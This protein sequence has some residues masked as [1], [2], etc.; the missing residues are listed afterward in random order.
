[1]SGIFSLEPD[2]FAGQAPVFGDAGDELAA[3]IRRL[4]ASIDGEGRCWGDDEPGRAFEKTYRPDAE[5]TVQN[6]QNLTSIL[7]ATGA[8][9]HNSAN[10]FDH[11]DLGSAADCRAALTDR[12]SGSTVDLGAPTTPHAAPA[13]LGTAPYETPGHHRRRQPPSTAFT[14]GPAVSAPASEAHTPSV[15]PPA[16]TDVPDRGTHRPG[17]RDAAECDRGSYERSRQGHDDRLPGNPHPRIVSPDLPGTGRTTE[18]IRATTIGSDNAVG[19]PERSAPSARPGTDARNPGG[20]RPG[21]PWQRAKSR[22]KDQKKVPKR[23]NGI[24]ALDG[25]DRPPDTTAP[26]ELSAP[27]AGKTRGTPWSERNRGDSRPLARPVA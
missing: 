12:G 3:A 6:V 1:M 7:R 27:I 16:G 8:L 24:V 14:A 20:S 25:P 23:P 22:G 10:Q 4:Q 21:N 19:S 15:A 11:R 17:E 5:R 13:A 9:V 26:S 18:P 2:E